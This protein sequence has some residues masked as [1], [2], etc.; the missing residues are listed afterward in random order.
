MNR[1][2]FFQDG[3]GAGAD[4]EPHDGGGGAPG[5]VQPVRGGGGRGNRVGPVVG[6]LDGLLVRLGHAAGQQQ[7][8]EGELR[9][10]MWGEGMMTADRGAIFLLCHRNTRYQYLICPTQLP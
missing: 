4:L 8:F 10:E 6:L 5:A 2:P 7:E 1:A 9:M 3:G